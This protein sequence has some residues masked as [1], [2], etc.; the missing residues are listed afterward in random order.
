MRLIDADNIPY[1]RT[2]DGDVVAYPDAIAE[3]PTIEQEPEIASTVDLI[4]RADAMEAVRKRIFQIGYEDNP[5]VLSLLQAVV[6]VPTIE[7][8]RK[9]G[10]WCVMDEPLGDHTTDLLIYCSECGQRSD[11]KS[12]NY[13]PN[14]G[15]DMRGST[16][17]EK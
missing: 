3:M 5:H 10:S 13:C 12:T 16:N 1:S 8:E 2:K 4:N 11:N 17:D 15:I 14:C 7:V 6:D 9:H